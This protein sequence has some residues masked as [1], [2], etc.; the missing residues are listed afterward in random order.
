MLFRTPP[1]SG[2]RL[3][4]LKVSCATWELFRAN[5]CYLQSEARWREP[6][7][8]SRVKRHY[9][10]HV[11]ISH[12]NIQV[13]KFA[14]LFQ[15]V[16]IHPPLVPQFWFFFSPQS[17]VFVTP[18]VRRSPLCLRTALIKH[19]VGDGAESSSWAE[20]KGSNSTSQDGA[21]T[22][23]GPTILSVPPRIP[24]WKALSSGSFLIGLRSSDAQTHARRTFKH[25]CACVACAHAHARVCPYVSL[26]LQLALLWAFQSALKANDSLFPFH[27]TPRP[28]S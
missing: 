26:V 25:S 7:D 18:C 20:E 8:A 6:D 23:N 3:I 5:C 21:V 4:E 12:S 13:I 16:W 24:G 27:S 28:L 17:P 1:T 14:Q 15:T 19:G 22:H 9:L 10:H 2:W 11:V